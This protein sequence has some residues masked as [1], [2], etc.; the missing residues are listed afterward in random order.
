MNKHPSAVGE[1]PE[2]KGDGLRKLGMCRQ[3]SGKKGSDGA[4]ARTAESREA[5]YL[6]IG[7][8]NH[9]LNIHVTAT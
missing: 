4:S 3:I 7:C 2:I 5:S 9:R 8:A 6:N 1:V